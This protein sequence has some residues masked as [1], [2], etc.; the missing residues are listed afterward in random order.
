VKEVKTY[1]VGG[2]VRDKLLGLSAIENDWVVVGSTPEEMINAGFRPIG[3]DFPVFLHPK[4]HEE[5]ALARTER[6]KSRGYKGFEFYT[7]PD[8]TLE[9]DLQR[10]DLTI[11]AIAM[12]EDEKIIDPYGGQKDLAQKILRH[13]SEAFP[14]DPVRILRVARFMARFAHLGFTIAPE[15]LQLMKTMVDNAEVD[16]LVADRVWQETEKALSEKSPTRFF[17]TL[18]N[19]G[20]L[21]KLFPEIKN[22]SFTTY[23]DKTICFSSLVLNLSPTEINTLCKHYPVPTEFRETALIANGLKSYFSQE[24]F[25]PEE[26]ISLLEKT[27]AF[28]R[29]DRFYKM[30]VF[31]KQADFLKKCFDAVKNINVEEFIQQGISGK[32]LGEMIREKRVGL[33]SSLSSRPSDT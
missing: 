21:Q 9:Q 25:T 26:I 1:L 12:T 2:A 28:R 23:P 3:K 11:N 18:Q 22:I 7:S 20:A 15:T 13:V 14:E 30:L 8:I 19:C 17:E 24:K 4:T 10:R 32:K 29:G 33:L 5:Y 31:F 27:D 6:K 16:A